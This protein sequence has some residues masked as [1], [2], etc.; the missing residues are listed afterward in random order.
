MNEAEEPELIMMK[1]YYVYIVE[2]ADNLLYTGIT[3]NISRRIDEHNAGLNRN[4]FT[5]KRRP[6][7]LIFYQD[8]ND[9]VQAIY[10][11]KKIKRWSAQKKRALAN[12]EEKL[13]KL[14]AEC[15]NESHHKNKPDTL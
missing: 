14:L 15:R 6:V 9:V 8:F 11:E 4:S 12:E 5:Y 7:K 2:C 3:N 1:L 13:L 10:F